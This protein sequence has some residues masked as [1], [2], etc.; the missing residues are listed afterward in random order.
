M[1]YTLQSCHYGSRPYTFD[2]VDT[3]TVP[4]Y[5]WPGGYPA[6]YVTPDGGILCGTCT[7]LM[8]TDD[9]Y[10]DHD[11]AIAGRFAGPCEVHASEHSTGLMCDHCNGW[12]VEP[13]CVECGDDF[14]PPGVT[15]GIFN[16]DSGSVV[17][18]GHCL[19]KQVVS[20][21]AKKTGKRTYQLTG[22]HWYLVNFPTT[23][24]R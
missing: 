5:F 15:S 23:F 22:N 6:E 2:S 10:A 8:L 24:T 3:D 21:H 20:G 13:H 4:D 9:S 14:T 19:A 1:T 7:R 12:I 17:I 18:C 11:D 16:D